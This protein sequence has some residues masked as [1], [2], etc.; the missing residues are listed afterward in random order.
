V[1]PPDEPR[2]YA[3]LSADFRQLRLVLEGLVNSRLPGSV[4]I[5]RITPALRQFLS[6]RGVTVLSA[7]PKLEQAVAEAS[8]VVH[9]GGIAT[10]LAALGMGRPQMLWPQVTDQ[11][12]TAQGLEALAVGE[13][14]SRSV[15]SN[16]EAAV[17]LRKFAD[18]R[19]KA[20]NAQTLAAHLAQR[21]PHGSLRTVVEKA[22][23]L[24][25]GRTG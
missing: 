21:H 5:K 11:T 16:A 8:V 18:D 24:L 13:I 6:E 3:Y 4:Y 20:R 23:A 22:R 19:E 1:P 10:S 25:A 17:A 2:F 9:H 12:V 14:A 7:A 15:K